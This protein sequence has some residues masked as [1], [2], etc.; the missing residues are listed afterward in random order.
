M[1]DSNT[2][3]S[4]VIRGGK[5][6]SHT[7]SEIKQTKLFAISQHDPVAEMTTQ[8]QNQALKG[9]SQKLS[10]KSSQSL[11][12]QHTTSSN[13]SPMNLTA[14]MNTTAQM[15]NA[16][17]P[18][19]A[20]TAQ[21]F[22][23]GQMGINM[24]S[25]GNYQGNNNNLAA[26]N[27]GVYTPL[28][29]QSSGIQP[30]V[31]G[32]DLNESNNQYAALLHILK[33]SNEMSTQ[34]QVARAAAILSASGFGNNTMTS[35]GPS[36]PDTTLAAAHAFVMMLNQQQ[37][38]GNQPQPQNLLNN[39]AN[40][41]LNSQQP[42][43]SMSSTLPRTPNL[44]HTSH[45]GA[46]ATSYD[47]KKPGSSASSTNIGE[48]RNFSLETNRQSS[49]NKH[50]NN[51]GQQPDPPFFSDNKASC[52]GISSTLLATLKHAGHNSKTSSMTHPQINQLSLHSLPMPL[53][54]MQVS[55]T[56]SLHHGPL[57]IAN[58]R[59]GLLQPTVSPLVLSQMQTWSLDQLGKHLEKV[60]FV[61]FFSMLRSRNCML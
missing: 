23:K 31:F 13:S 61:K 37:L 18:T 7:S 55:Q 54:S 44:S 53:A 22:I 48:E 4:S 41:H 1:S 26:V 29:V 16:M 17:F 35:Q 3:T 43:M 32:M 11:Q 6:S 5:P 60:D 25:N 24:Q 52:N 56:G 59:K 21:Q 19:P 2:T 46:T 42:M 27:Q 57:K 51:M 20:V 8:Y 38:L 28:G 33:Q 47:D 9:E 40:S 39:D 36:T 34:S 49:Q 10:P 30:P 14:N 58:N 15:Q 50:S 12:D 45:K